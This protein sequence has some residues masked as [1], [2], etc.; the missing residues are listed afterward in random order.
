MRLFRK[1]LLEVMPT[2]ICMTVLGSLI[3]TIS[4]YM[5]YTNTS[6]Y[7][8]IEIW[9]EGCGWMDFF[10]P[11]ITVAPF[12]YTLYMKRKDNYLMYVSVRMDTKKY[13]HATILAGML[14]V[15]L[16]VFFIYFLSLI[17]SIKCIYHGADFENKY[18]LNYIFGFMQAEHPIAFGFIWCLWK[19][20]VASLFTWFGYRLSLYISN[21]FLVSILPFLYCMAEN[22]CLSLLGKP[23]L[24]LTTTYVLNRLS[25]KV[26]HIWNYGFG[27]ITY[28]ISVAIIMWIIKRKR[29]IHYET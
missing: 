3:L 16:S 27:I 28:F 20:Y 5:V 22:M 10:L 9:I 26:M 6:I 8:P 18:I 21:V 7:Y 4:C 1:M 25:P 17:I 24:S 29:G 2:A 13:I 19:G 15:G 12:S 11:L 14:T 23:E